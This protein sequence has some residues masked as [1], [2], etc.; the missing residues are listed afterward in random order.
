[1]AVLPLSF[2]EAAYHILRFRPD[3]VLGVGGYVTGPV[4]AMARILGRPTVIHEQNSVP[5]L[6]NRKLGRLADRICL[7]IPGSEN[8]FPSRKGG[9]DRQSGAAGRSLI[10]PSSRQESG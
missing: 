6:A 3:L 9:P 2:L 10:W 4:V 8:Y 5:G 1:M 7:S